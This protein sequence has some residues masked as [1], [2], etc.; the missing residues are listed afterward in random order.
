VPCFAVQRGIR[1]LNGQNIPTHLL[2]T[3]QKNT[4][5]LESGRINEG[6][7]KE[8]EKELQ[9]KIN[10]KRKEGERMRFSTRRL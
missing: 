9:E 10:E 8:F 3:G 6:R 4:G 7:M 2:E 5:E 1:G